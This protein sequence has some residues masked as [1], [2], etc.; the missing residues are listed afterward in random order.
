MTGIYT[1]SY[2]IEKVGDSPGVVVEVPY[3]SCHVSWRS[4]R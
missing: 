1:F 3:G 2:P 4:S